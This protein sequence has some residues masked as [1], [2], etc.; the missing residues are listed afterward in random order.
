VVVIWA[1]PTT[2]EKCCGLYFLAD[3]TKFSIDLQFNRKLYNSLV[4]KNKSHVLHR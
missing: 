3:T 1:C 4:P 2:V